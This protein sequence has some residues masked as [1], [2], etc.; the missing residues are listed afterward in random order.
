[1]A[2]MISEKM[3]FLLKNKGSK[4]AEKRAP[5]ESVLSATATFETLIAP[6][7]AIQC[8]PIVTPIPKSKNKSE[9]LSFKSIFLILKIRYSTRAATVTLNQTSGMV[10]ASMSFPRTPVNPQRR[11]MN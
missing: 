1:M 5:V 7:N 8:R 9:R 10:E 4:K 3:I 11:T 2:N 6:K